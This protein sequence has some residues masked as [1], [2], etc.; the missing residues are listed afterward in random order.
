[1]AALLQ[2]VRPAP[3][4][5]SAARGTSCGRFAGRLGRG[6]CEGIREGSP[7][8]HWEGHTA[9]ANTRRLTATLQA[10]LLPA[11]L[12][13]T[14]SFAQTHTVSV[15]NGASKAGAPVSKYIYGQFLEH[16]GSIVNSGIWAEMLDDRKFYDTPWDVSPKSRS[17]S[18]G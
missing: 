4:P 12:F 13:S 16:I 2:G 17:R 11:L 6:I 7:T 15:T 10:V 1:V 8:S 18:R 14:L 5:L 9:Q 3:V